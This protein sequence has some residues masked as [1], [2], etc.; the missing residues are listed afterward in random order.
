M[1]Q[2]QHYLAAAAVAAVAQAGTGKVTVHPVGM[3]DNFINNAGGAGPNTVTGAPAEP[4]EKSIVYV[5]QTANSHKMMH[6]R[7]NLPAHQYTADDHK[8]ANNLKPL[9]E[10]AK[11]QTGIQ[12]PNQV[13]KNPY[14]DDSG[15]FDSQKAAVDAAQAIRTAD[16]YM[17]T[18][19]FARRDE[20]SAMTKDDFARMLLDLGTKLL[21][22]QHQEGEHLS[23]RAA[24]SQD[25]L[26][27]GL[28]PILQLGFDSGKLFK[29]DSFDNAALDGVYY[30]N[31]AHEGKYDADLYKDYPATDSSKKLAADIT[32]VFHYGRETAQKLLSR[33][34]DANG[35]NF[36]SQRAATDVAR[37]YSIAKRLRGFNM[38][39]ADG[40]NPGDV[41]SQH[42][43]AL[44]EMANKLFQA[45]DEE[46]MNKRD[47]SQQQ[48]VEAV[49]PLMSRAYD[50]YSKMASKHSENGNFN[51][52]N[53]IAKTATGMEQWSK[54]VNLV[55]E[56]K[57]Q[58][59]Y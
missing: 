29:Y 17:R 8:L 23:R 33:Y 18:L 46:G 10:E 34:T 9:I 25:D 15:K 53:A 1:V 11:S 19:G 31:R 2:V 48:I 40:Q 50:I 30:L 41:H 58:F 24:P 16:G 21:S 32:P 49:A 57:A 42:G 39:I 28:K 37:I 14:V 12:S 47:V 7:A 22:D 55:A 44:V 56:G 45:E 52:E 5:T 51:Y 36:D 43:F 3:N 54:L 20:S 13:K 38:N 26:V 27:R 35:Q 4:R 6:K 59:P